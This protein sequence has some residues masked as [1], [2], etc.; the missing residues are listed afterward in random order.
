MTTPAM[1]ALRA[2]FP[3]AE[4][5]VA[6]NPVVGELFSFHPY[7]NRVMVFDKKKAHRGVNGLF[8]FSG[9]LR[10]ERF[11][12]AVLF[13]NAVEAALMALLAGIPNR[14][15]YRTDGRGILLT[16]G[17]PIGKAERRLH[18]TAYYMHMLSTLGIQEGNGQLSLSC[19]SRE[20][21]WAREALESDSS[22]EWVALNPG[23]AYGS[24]KRWLP[25]RFAAVADALAQEFGSRILLIGGPGETNIGHEIEA[26][27]SVRPLNLIGKTSVRQ[28]MALLSQ[29]RLMVTND[30]GPMHVAA[31]FGVPIVALFGS[32]DHT[33]TSPLSSSC[34][35]VRKPLECAPCL[36]RS[37]PT[38]HRCMEA[39]TVQDVLDAVRS[40]LRIQGRR[41]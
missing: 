27:M 12:L 17:A 7:C 38:D 16:H 29:C 26:A 13:Q 39:I 25:E 20:E 14:A 1:G 30:S 11:D 23:A 18:H 3:R 4:V 24:A 22:G 19:T 36:K 6:A 2:A 28:L 21:S 32:T 35:I 8:R 41:G 15:G 40:S 5:V 10:A 33:T 34:R 37:C 31:A 9:E